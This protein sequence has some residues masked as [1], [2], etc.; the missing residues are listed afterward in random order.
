[1]SRTDYVPMVRF[2]LPALLCFLFAS[3]C[4]QGECRPR[5][6]P[7]TRAQVTIDQGVWGNVWFWE[8]DFMPVGWG[9]ITPV[10]R[11][12][13]AFE[14]TTYDQVERLDHASFYRTIRTRLVASTESNS[15]GFFQ[16]ALPRGRYSFFVREGSSFYASF[17]DGT[18]IMPATVYPDSVTKLQIDIN[19]KACF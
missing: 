1:M 9:K 8:G 19:Y 2:L 10:R 5:F 6:P 4:R 14:P 12:V 13:Y 11:T 3:G 7:D 18:Y 17:D 15:S 16:L